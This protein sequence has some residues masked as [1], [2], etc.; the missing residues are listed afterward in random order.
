MT[1]GLS[2]LEGKDLIAV[3][4]AIDTLKKKKKNGK[5]RKADEQ[6]GGNISQHV[7]VKLGILLGCSGNNISVTVLWDR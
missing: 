7:S 6:K 5:T 1:E 2:H 4:C 3:G